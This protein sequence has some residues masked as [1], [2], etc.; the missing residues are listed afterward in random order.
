LTEPP[1]HLDI[2]RILETLD[3]HG[4]QYL[5]VGGIAAAMHGATRATS[6]F[7]CLPARDEENLCRLAA[8]LNELRARFRVGG[9]TDEESKQLGVIIDQV[10]LGRAQQTTWRTDAG[11]LDVLTD[12]S[13]PGSRAGFE[14]LAGEAVR[15][16]IGST[17]VRLI[18]LEDLIASKEAADRPKDHEALPELRRLRDG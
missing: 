7:D 4:V 2:G 14:Q 3:R 18:G 5:V 10:L 8:A 11:D 13:Y 6:D 12:V 15:L 16:Q 17:S 9:M 1:P